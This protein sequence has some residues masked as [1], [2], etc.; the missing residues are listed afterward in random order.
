[1]GN[2]IMDVKDILSQSH[3][4]IAGI[5]LIKPKIDKIGDVSKIEPSSSYNK[6][7]VDLELEKGALQE[8]KQV[9]L[10]RS[11]RLKANNRNNKLKVKAVSNI[12]SKIVRESNNTPEGKK[13]Q[14]F[15]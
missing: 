5:K 10:R 15:N 4:A 13:K 12:K 7:D 6:I 9:V 3:K 1:M 8:E 14:L 11:K 2:Q